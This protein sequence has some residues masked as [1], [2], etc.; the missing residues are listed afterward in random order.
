MLNIEK[1]REMDSDKMVKL[2]NGNKCSMC[3]YNNTNCLK[4]FCSI[5]IEEWLNQECEL[6]IDDVYGEY[7]KFCCTRNCLGCEYPDDTCLYHFL[8]DHFIIID[9]KITRRQK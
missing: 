8:A 5:G 6:T 3:T 2:L 4:E 9:G 7:D 1:I